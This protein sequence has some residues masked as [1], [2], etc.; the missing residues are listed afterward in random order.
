MDPV[1]GAFQNW[2]ED[3]IYRHRGK[4]SLDGNYKFPP[5]G[6]YSPYQHGDLWY[7]DMR[8]PGLFDEKIVADDSSLQELAQKII[9]EPSFARATV[10]FWWPSVMK[11]PVLLPPAVVEDQDYQARFLAY[12]AQ[13]TAVQEFADAFT[14]SNFNLKDLLTDMMMSPWFRAGTIVDPG[15]SDALLAAELGREKLLTPENLQRKT[16]ALTGHN[17][18]SVPSPYEI[19]MR[20]GF[21]DQYKLYYGGIDS[22]ATTERSRELTALMMAVAETHAFE[23]ACPIVI[24]EFALPDENRL[25]FD[26]ISSDV[27]PQSGEQEIRQKLVDLHQRLLGKTYTA[28]SAEIDIAY[29]LFAD[30]WTDAVNNDTN[31]SLTDSLYCN[32]RFDFN[33]LDGLDFEGPSHIEK[34]HERGWTYYDFN[35][36][37]AQSLI[38]SMTQDPHSTL[39]SWRVVM[40][41]LLTHYHYLY[42]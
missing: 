25:L 42:E 37:G 18:R 40:I 9:Q 23:S 16:R 10:K 30:S 13:S 24:K 6:E 11:T 21:N 41:Y 29:Q 5:N 12:K 33:F 14:V 2:N 26:G 34:V 20:G 19:D 3:G 27:T 8:D 32:P 39:S 15:K 4:D 31:N 1:A 28:D 17:W 36:E 35:Q 22:L 38:S 7:R